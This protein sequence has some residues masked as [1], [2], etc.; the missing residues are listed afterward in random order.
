MNSCS[1]STRCEQLL[2]L[3]D[4]AVA[5]LAGLEPGDFHH[6]LFA[7]GQELMQRRIDGANR[8]RLAFHR[9]EHAVE[10]LALQRQ[11]LVQRRAA[12]G[13]VVGENHA[14]HDRDAA[15]AEEHVLGAAEANAARAKRVGELRLI[16]QDRRWRARP[17]DGTCPTRRAAG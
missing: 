7:L 16:G 6:Q 3:G 2:A 14:L 13:L 17:S 11:Q 5:A 10:V 12:V 4:V 9:L 1:C 8:D 15:F